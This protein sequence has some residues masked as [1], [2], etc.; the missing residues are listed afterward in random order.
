MNF[1]GNENPFGIVK[2]TA[3]DD[4]DFYNNLNSLN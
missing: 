3:R 2:M 1:N 4:P